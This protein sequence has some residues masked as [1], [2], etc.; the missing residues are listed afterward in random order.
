MIAV[1]NVLPVVGEGAV[2]SARGR[3]QF[4]LFLGDGHSP[5]DAVV[6]AT[7]DALLVLCQVCVLRDF[8]I[9]HEDARPGDVAHG[10]DDIVPRDVYGRLR[11]DVADAVA[12]HALHRDARIKFV[13]IGV[14]HQRAGDAVHDLVNVAGIDFL[15]H[16]F[17]PKCSYA[18]TSRA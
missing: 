5:E 17:P 1:Q 6:P 13:G 18:T 8:H 2:D 14:I 11:D 3:G 12:D 7:D 4:P 10:A 9:V 16:T 15:E